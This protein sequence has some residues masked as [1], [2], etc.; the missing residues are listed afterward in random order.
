M[1]LSPTPDLILKMQA[2]LQPEKVP[3]LPD[4]PFDIALQVFTDV[5][6][7]V[8][9]DSN[10]SDNEVLAIVGKSALESILTSIL[11]HRMPP[12]NAEELK[13]LSLPLCL[14]PG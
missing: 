12:L 3:S 13:V 7:R 4:V 10:R 14:L 8:P 9:G 11:F 2:N 6:L 1:T 5:S